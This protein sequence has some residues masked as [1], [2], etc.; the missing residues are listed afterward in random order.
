VGERPGLL[1]FRNGFRFEV[2]NGFADAANYNVLWVPGGDPTALAGLMGAPRRTF[3]DFL[4]A[5]SAT[6]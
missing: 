5:K 4:I 1:R 2:T 3:L 6:G